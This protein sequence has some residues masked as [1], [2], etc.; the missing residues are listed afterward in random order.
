MIYMAGFRCNNGKDFSSNRRGG[1]VC[2]P[3]LLIMGPAEVGSPQ[4]NLVH[5]D[6]VQL[7]DS[8]F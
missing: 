1:E 2:Q 5:V 6:F 7:C 4:L 8:P 3:S